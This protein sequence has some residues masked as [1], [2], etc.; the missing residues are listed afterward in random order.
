MRCQFIRLRS[1]AFTRYLARLQLVA[2][3]RPLV[4]GE[5]GLDTHR[6]GET[7]QAEALGWAWGAVLRAGLAGLFAQNL[8][9]LKLER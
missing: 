5:F 6:H 8:I 7:R 4:V 1:S 3:D 2:G 9:Q